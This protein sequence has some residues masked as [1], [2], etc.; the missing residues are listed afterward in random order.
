MASAVL[1]IRTSPQPWKTWENDRIEAHGH[2]TRQSALMLGR[3][4]TGKRR[5]SRTLFHAAG[6]GADAADDVA[7]GD[8]IAGLG[9]RAFGWSILMFS[10][11]NLIPMPIGSNMVTAIP[12]ILLT[13]QMAAGF[14]YIRLPGFLKR[15]RISRRGFQRVVLGLG[16]LI[17]P[18]EKIVSPRHVWLFRPRN[19]RLIGVFMLLVSLALFV[20]IPLSGFIPAT[21]LFVCAF[22]LIE[23]DGLVTFAGLGLGLISI[24]VTLIVGGLLLAG[25]QT[26]A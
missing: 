22:G 6:R 1:P 19:E 26:L 13:G 7:F 5:L 11:V 10:L 15:R 21:A 17:R 12:L 20:P 14:R 2:A 8:L 23:R 24:I 4:L 3:P 16:P 9:D 18:I 25:A